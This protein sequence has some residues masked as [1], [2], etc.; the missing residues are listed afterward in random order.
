M[1]PCMLYKSKFSFFYFGFSINIISSLPTGMSTNFTF[2]NISSQLS[3]LTI[4]DHLQLCWSTRFG[5]LGIT[6]LSGFNILFLL[7]LCISVLCMGL[8]QWR[9]Q[10]TGTP[11]SHSDILTFH[12][13]ILELINVLGSTLSCFGIHTNNIVMKTVGIYLFANVFSGQMMFH[14]VTCA[15]RYL[16][17][18]HPII[19]RALKST[20]GIRMRNITI[21]CIW[22]MCIF[23]LGY[24]SLADQRILT[25]LSFCM[26]PAAVVFMSFCSISVLYVLLRPGPGRRCRNRQQVDPSKRRAF[27]TIMAILSVLLIR[28]GYHICVNGLH[29][30]QNMKYGNT[31]AIW[32]SETW[33]TVPSSLVMP[34]LFL[35]KARKNPHCRDH[36]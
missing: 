10:S 2:S 12:I 13:V 5:T 26:V 9:Q 27:Y 14:I 32:L 3:P 35:H 22:L 29:D 31:C 24:L 15:E 7:P 23:G 30:P 36:K 4:F 16:A 17:V 20:K 11:L 18:V 8:K 28:F 21:S 33:F 6:V 1:P 25:I 34:L 19:Y